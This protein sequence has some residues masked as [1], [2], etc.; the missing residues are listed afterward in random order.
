MQVWP[1]AERAGCL[2]RAHDGGFYP[3]TSNVATPKG[4]ACSAILDFSGPALIHCWVV[5]LFGPFPLS[6]SSMRTNCFGRC[7]YALPDLRS[8]LLQ[9]AP[10]I[11]S[12]PFVIAC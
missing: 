3:Q 10:G 2:P 12:S 6:P 1:D 11:L 8:R 7:P 9:S 4:V 5:R